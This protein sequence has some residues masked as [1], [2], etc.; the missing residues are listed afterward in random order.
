MN[1]EVK[2]SIAFFHNI[3]QVLANNLNRLCHVQYSPDKIF[4]LFS[5]VAN[6]SLTLFLAIFPCKQES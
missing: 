1:A 5:R 2:F 6:N 3:E 4:L